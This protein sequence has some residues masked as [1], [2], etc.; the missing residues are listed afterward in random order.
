MCKSKCVPYLSFP[1]FLFG[2]FSLVFLFFFLLMAFAPAPLSASRL[3]DTDTYDKRPVALIKVVSA[4]DGRSLRSYP[5]DISGCGGKDKKVRQLGCLPAE[6]LQVMVFDL[7]GDGEMETVYL[8]D[9]GLYVYPFRRM[10]AMAGYAI[11]SPGRPQGFSCGP[12]LIVLNIL[13]PEIGMRSV[14]LRYAGGQLIPVL[15]DVNLWLSFVDQGA[16]RQGE[17]LIVQGFDPNIWYAREVYLAEPASRDIRY[18]KS[19]KLPPFFNVTRAL[20]QDLNS[21]GYKELITIG[22]DRK[23]RIYESDSL[24]TTIDLD[25]LPGTLSEHLTRL[26]PYDVNGDGRREVIFG[27]SSAE[28][29]SR[30]LA[31][32]WTGSRYSV[33]PVSE[34]FTGRLCGVSVNGRGQLFAAVVKEQKKGEKKTLLYVLD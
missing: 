5:L 9:K 11:G 21:N 23:I 28:G 8:T 24:L 14:L 31:L 34:S 33:S 30:I 22:F 4:E 1:P 27:G 16:D 29:K 2:R 32:M 17:S 6:A 20:W 19:L 12:G 10:G 3:L 26:I 18:I 13:M 15:E 25:L 7:S